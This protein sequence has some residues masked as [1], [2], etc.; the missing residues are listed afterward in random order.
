MED[1]LLRLRFSVDE[2]VEVGDV[3]ADVGLDL[4]NVIGRILDR[5]W[6]PPERRRADVAHL[7]SKIAIR[8]RE[9]AIEGDRADE[10]HLI[11]DHAPC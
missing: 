10:L 1:T 3:R 6:S 8:T 5:P 2:G 4:T 11:L 7:H 9:G